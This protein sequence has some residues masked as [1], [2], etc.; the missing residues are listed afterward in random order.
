MLSCI[1]FLRTP[2]MSLWRTLPPYLPARAEVGTI[3]SAARLE[4]GQVIEKA[5][6]GVGRLFQ[7]VGLGLG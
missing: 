2:M 6:N 3:D 4:V 5:G 7:K 1:V